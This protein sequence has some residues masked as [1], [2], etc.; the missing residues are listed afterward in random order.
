MVKTELETKRDSVGGRLGNI[1][2][3]DVYYVV[4]KALDPA[5]DNDDNVVLKLNLGIASGDISTYFFN[6]D[7]QLLELSE[8]I[9]KMVSDYRFAMEKKQSIRTSIEKDELGNRLKNI[10]EKIKDLESEKE[11]IV[12]ILNGD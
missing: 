4:G 10:D 7:K 8:N 11:E 9:A 12:R 5:Y 2:T 1:S 6:D 3:Y